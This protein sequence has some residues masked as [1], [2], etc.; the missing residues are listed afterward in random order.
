MHLQSQN[1]IQKI[2]Y[3]Q[4]YGTP[5]AQ[6][7]WIDTPIFHHGADNTRMTIES[8]QGRGNGQ[9]SHSYREIVQGAPRGEFARLK[10]VIQS[11][12]RHQIRVHLASI[13]HP[14]VGDK[15]YMTK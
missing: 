10:V 3:A 4:V 6:L 5:R 13:G 14:I 11:G 7:G 15:L 2:Y 9:E 12:T 1:Q 8:S